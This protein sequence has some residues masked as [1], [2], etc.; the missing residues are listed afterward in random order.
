MYEFYY[1]KFIPFYSTPTTC[2]AKL[3]FTDTD[4]LCYEVTT[5]DIYYDMRQNPN[6]FDTSNYDTSHLKRKTK[7][8]LGR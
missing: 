7:K 4:S 2:N 8:L 1:D 5:K 6:W 3:L